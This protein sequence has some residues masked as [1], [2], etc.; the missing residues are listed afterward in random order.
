MTLSKSSDN[1]AL[2]RI[3]CLHGGGVNA[4]IFRMQARCFIS[5]LAPYFRLVFVD[6]PFECSP[7]Y[8]IL[9]VYG[10]F[11]P[12]RRWMRWLPEHPE[13]S[14][15]AASDAITHALTAGMT[16]D[17]GTGPWVGVLGFSQGSKLASSLLFTQQA[18]RETL[19]RDASPWDFRF[20]VL[21]AGSAPPVVLD[22]RLQAPPGIDS[23]E[24]LGFS[25]DA[26][27]ERPSADEE[28]RALQPS[29]H[30]IR[31]PTIHIHG[32]RDPGLARH[33]QLLELYTEPGSAQLIEWDGDHR[34]PITKIEVEAMCNAI[35][36]LAQKV[37]V[38][39]KSRV[40]TL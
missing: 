9:E 16:A 13:L 32:T 30:L 36:A 17:P 7:H 11:G 20:G 40:S 4:E 22:M 21:M 38:L 23:P 26:W 19:G 10:E 29:E 18:L 39:D 37:G 35:V 24:T 5:T 25:F 34:V 2:P 8:A 31:T 14:A 15:T 33:R 28:E 6:A 1:L 12:F 27:P 3:L